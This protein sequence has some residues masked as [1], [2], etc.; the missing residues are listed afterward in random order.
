MS[1][2]SNI[3]N[4]LNQSKRDHDVIIDNR[5]IISMTGIDEVISFDENTVVLS[6]GN[7]ISTVDGQGLNITK[8]S[9]DTGDVVIEGILDG[10]FYSGQK[11]Q[12]NGL[13]S[14]F[15]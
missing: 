13:F 4:T 7:D 1:I 14:R 12:K 10:M 9:L 15:R 6:C 3:P 5:K 2:Q 11:Q 8:L